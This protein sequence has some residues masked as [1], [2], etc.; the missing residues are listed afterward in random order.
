MTI[1]PMGQSPKL[2][3]TLCNIP[4]KHVDVSSHIPRTADSNG[5]EEVRI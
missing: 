2:E 5:L 3:G 4:V 1:M